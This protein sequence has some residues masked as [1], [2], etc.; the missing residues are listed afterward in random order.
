MTADHE[1]LSASAVLEVGRTVLDGEVPIANGHR[2]R[3]VLT[4]RGEPDVAA[5]EVQIHDADGLRGLVE[6]TACVPAAS[7]SRARAFFAA[8]RRALGSMK[9]ETWATWLIDLSLLATSLSDEESF[10]RALTNTRARAAARG[11][12]EMREFLRSCGIEDAHD[13]ETLALLWRVD[14][15]D[16]DCIRP[17]ARE[18]AARPS[19]ALSR[20]VL[21][22]VDRWR[23]KRADA[24]GPYFWDARNVD[25][26]AAAGAT[27]SS[28]VS[29]V[30]GETLRRRVVACFEA[31]LLGG[32]GRAD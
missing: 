4:Y 32:A 10:Y 24:G 22:V 28:L 21:E 2:A 15:D 3:L 1:L 5:I 29:A 30:E 19:A 13:D 11:P 7:A 9:D 18:L 25:V 6:W 31:G 16:V 17:A 23:A 12:V 14:S 20:A 27:L 26:Q 8:A